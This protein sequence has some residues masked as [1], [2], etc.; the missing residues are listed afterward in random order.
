MKKDL[1]TWLT[2]SNAFYSVIENTTGYLGDKLQTIRGY[3]ENDLLSQ[4]WNN[5]RSQLA[6]VRHQIEDK[7][8]EL[9]AATTVFLQE[10]EL[11]YWTKSL[12]ESAATDFDQAMDAVYLKTHIGG[13]QHRLFDGGHSLL[14]SW[15][16]GKAAL[17]EDVTILDWVLAY[18]KDLTTP[19]GM[20]FV[21]VDKTDFDR[22]ASYYSRT[23]TPPHKQYFYDLFTFDAL[24]IIA[25]GL[26]VAAVCFAL[27]KED[28]KK[29]AKI[30]GAMGASSITAANPILGLATIFV[31]AYAY[32]KHGSIDMSGVL[33]GSALTFF[34]AFMFSFLGMPVM[35]ELAI[36]LSLSIIL[37]KSLFESD[38][39]IAWL[40]DKA[41]NA[42]SEAKDLLDFQKLYLF[43]NQREQEEK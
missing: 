16:A 28:K 13:N 38:E 14:G 25:T 8:S 3:H 32:W 40:T 22:W 11:S 23:I 42:L 2:D 15:Q 17:G 5:I 4:A 20:P 41:V 6:E 1:P 30:L 10:R 33:K 12:T 26:S 27:N 29:L 24:E 34:S 35:V 18:M 43:S 9:F 21:T 31:T 39:F 37:R 36:V 7:G 19:M